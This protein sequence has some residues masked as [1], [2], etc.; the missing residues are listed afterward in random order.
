MSRS[1]KTSGELAIDI[2]CNHKSSGDVVMYIWCGHPLSLVAGQP[3]YRGRLGSWCAIVAFGIV[4]TLRVVSYR[5]RCGLVPPAR[6]LRWIQDKAQ[7]R[8]GAR[9]RRL[10]KK[11]HTGHESGP[12]GTASSLDP[13]IHSGLSRKI[14]FSWRR[15]PWS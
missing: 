12:R 13:W 7:D 11:R 2:W 5:A 8:Q 10:L 9:A 15:S 6:H 14:R 1:Y 3:E 4:P